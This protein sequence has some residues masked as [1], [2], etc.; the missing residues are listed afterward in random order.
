[1]RNFLKIF[2]LF[3]IIALLCSCDAPRE[4]PLDPQNPD[5]EIY[6]LSGVV[7]T[8]GF[9]NN[10]IPGVKVYW[11]N[12]NKLVYTSQDGHY[13]IGNIRKKNGWLR[14]EH[15]D[16]SPDSIHIIWGN[17]KK[18]ESQSFLNTKPVLD[19]IDL[20][21]IVKNRYQVNQ[22]FEIMISTVITDA[23]GSNDIDSVY[24]EIAALGISNSLP[25]T[26]SNVY[27]RKLSLLELN[28]TSLDEVIG[29]E[30]IIYVIDAS[31]RVFNT[32]SSNLKRVIR[33]E[34]NIISPLGGEIVNNPVSLRWERFTPGF[35]FTYLIQI[36]T[37]ES[38]AELVWEK[39]NIS[40]GEISYQPDTTL[41]AGNYFWVIWCIDEFQN[42]CSSKP[43]TFTVEQ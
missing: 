8:I 4:N 24:F 28:I 7:K 23:E 16:Y 35:E 21:S 41:A 2:P 5:N 12:D 14:F 27:E 37:D 33:Q 43:A 26:V 18:I 36:S 19:N 22:I 11:E 13:Q 29:H 10:P 30:F 17:Q 20:Y 39:Y 15:A 6:E 34:I 38:P 3:I 25:N 32:G 31:G 1:M 42:R 40:S 9:P